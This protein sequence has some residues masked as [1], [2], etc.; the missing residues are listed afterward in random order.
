MADQKQT[1]VFRK[2]WKEAIQDLPGDVRLEIYEC[3]IEYATSGNV[4]ELKSMAK[5]AFGFI[6]NTIER[7]QSKYQETII[8]KS[9][10]GRF[11]NLKRW[12]PDLYEQVQQE[13][14][15]LDEAEKIAK[16]RKA[17]QRDKFIANVAV[18][19]SDSDSVS[20]SVSDSD[21]YVD[22][23]G[24]I[25]SNQRIIELAA[26][27]NKIEITEVKKLISDFVEQKSAV[28]E[29]WKNESDAFKNF[30]YWIPKH[31]N[32][33]KTN[34]NSQPQKLNNG[35]FQKAKRR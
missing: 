24:A 9:E 16:R 29:K 23:A 5:V 35:S 31:V 14:I 13:N 1:F 32:S 34:S 27:Q 18:S 25:N 11:G 21:Y 3:I 4:P 26:M 28:K 15:S 30:L 17:S 22:V 2:E 33:Q 10:S 8:Q 7:D 19:V 20:I 12:H 6:K